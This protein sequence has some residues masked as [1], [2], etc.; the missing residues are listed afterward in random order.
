MRGRRAAGS[1]ALALSMAGVGCG[2]P[3]ASGLAGSME[4][5]AVKGT[6]R[7]RGKPVTDGQIVFDAS[8]IYRRVPEKVAPIGKDGGYEVKTLVGENAIEV[9]CKELFTLK[10]RGPLG[11][12][13]TVRIQPGENTIDI[14]IPPKR[15]APLR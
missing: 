5:A 2:N 9:K 1:L 8:N 14:D 6:V 4:Q 3:R 10:T 11:N 13:Q 15:S 7:V 12:E